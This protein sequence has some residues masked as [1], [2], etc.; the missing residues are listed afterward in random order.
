MNTY[1]I[2]DMGNSFHYNNKGPIFGCCRAGHGVLCSTRRH[3]GHATRARQCHP[4]GIKSLSQHSLCQAVGISPT[5]ICPWWEADRVRAHNCTIQEFSSQAAEQPHP[6][7]ENL[8]HLPWV[9]PG[10]YQRFTFARNCSMAMS[11][12]W[13]Y[14]QPWIYSHLQREGQLKENQDVTSQKH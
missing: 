12:P 3:W 5:S 2:T 14:I 6:S 13:N 8:H 9:T 10:I 7:L 11:H 4:Q 1:K